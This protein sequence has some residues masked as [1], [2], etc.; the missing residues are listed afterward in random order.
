MRRPC[1][2]LPRLS[3]AAASNATPAAASLPP[4]HR[5]P[6]RSSPSEP[7]ESLFVDI[8]KPFSTASVTGGHA[9]LWFAMPVFARKL[10]WISPPWQVCSGGDLVEAHDWFRVGV[11]SSQFSNWLLARL[12]AVG[13]EGL[14]G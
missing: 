7:A 14:L 11:L 5:C 1:N 6:P 9:L 8:L 3:V 2:L 13:R 10:M 12:K 4:H